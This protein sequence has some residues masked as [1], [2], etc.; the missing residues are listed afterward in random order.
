MAEGE[1]EAEQLKQHKL[2]SSFID[3][4][5]LSSLNNE[6]RLVRTTNKNLW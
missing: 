1:A 5:K 4:A 2:S 6:R 3:R